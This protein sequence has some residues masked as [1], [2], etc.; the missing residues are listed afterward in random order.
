MLSPIVCAAPV[1]FIST[2]FRVS[3]W[4]GRVSTN[5]A[6]SRHSI[7]LCQPYSSQACVTHATFILDRGVAKRID[8]SIA[9]EIAFCAVHEILRVFTSILWIP[10]EH[11]HTHTLPVFPWFVFFGFGFSFTLL[12][13]LAARLVRSNVTKIVWIKRASGNNEWIERRAKRTH[14]ISS[15]SASQLMLDSFSHRNA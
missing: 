13:R 12:C 5:Y 11:T 1:F 10:N 7:D 8:L 6:N 2:H 3:A 14:L 4:F 9:S 15:A